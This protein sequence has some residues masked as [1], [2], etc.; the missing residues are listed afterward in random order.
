MHPRITRSF[1]NDPKV[2]GRERLKGSSDKVF[3]RRE[4]FIGLRKRDRSERRLKHTY[5]GIKNKVTLLSTSLL[6]KEFRGAGM[7]G[8]VGGCAEGRVS[9]L[10]DHSRRY[11]QGGGATSLLSGQCRGRRQR[12]PGYFCEKSE[13]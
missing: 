1:K 2:L 12:K 6:L 11:L 8:R 7:C 5:I 9:T 10:G 3:N 13:R 4:T